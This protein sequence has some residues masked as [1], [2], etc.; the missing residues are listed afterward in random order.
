MST[1][2]FCQSPKAP[3]AH[4]RPSGISSPEQF[5]AALLAPKPAHEHKPAQLSHARDTD[6]AYIDEKYLTKYTTLPPNARIYLIKYLC[7]A[8]QKFGKTVAIAQTGLDYL[9]ELEKISIDIGWPSDPNEHEHELV[10]PANKNDESTIALTSPSLPAALASAYDPVSSAELD[11]AVGKLKL[12]TSVTSSMTTIGASDSSPYSP[13]SS[14]SS[15]QL[16]TAA[17]SFEGGATPIEDCR[18]IYAD[19]HDG[20]NKGKEVCVDGVP[21]SHT[22]EDSRSSNISGEP[23]NAKLCVSPC[24]NTGDTPLKDSKNDIPHGVKFDQLAWD[25]YVAKY[26]EELKAFKRFDFVHMVHA[27]RYYFVALKEWQMDGYRLPVNVP[28]SENWPRYMNSL[29]NKYDEIED[30]I[31]EMKVP[32]LESTIALRKILGLPV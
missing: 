31:R 24:C 16:S 11:R 4:R 25:H 30:K 26:K 8:A 13:E 5:K 32:D 29:F 14:I 9:I 20:A 3:P 1:A 27:H 2:N 21:S 23:H 7:D 15:P 10:S 18:D 12:S 17:T 6:P 19:A 22:E 28:F